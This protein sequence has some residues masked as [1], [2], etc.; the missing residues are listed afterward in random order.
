MWRTSSHSGGGNDCVEV[1][2]KPHETAVRD[3]KNPAG[4]RLRFTATEW[5]AFVGLTKGC[6][7]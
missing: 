3:S 7:A 6:Q 4:P 1:A 2:I 5:S